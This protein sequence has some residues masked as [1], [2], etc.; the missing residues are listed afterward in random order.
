MGTVA[1]ITAEKYQPEELRDLFPFLSS[2]DM[3]ELYVYLEV[4]EWQAGEV[5]LRSG[6]PG[7][8]LGFLTAGRL[9][10]KKEG[11]FPGRFVLV[12]VLERGS[13]V[14]E[15][16]ATGGQCQAT[17]IVMEDCQFLALS[18]E[19]LALLLE[20]SPALGRK[21]LLRIIHILGQRLGKANER[22]ARLL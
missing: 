20:R 13:L 11:I 16:A 19:N 21:L 9:A 7:D 12:A 3:E 17:V 8:F 4:R 18:R 5:V 1:G 22:L 2:E 6:E 10:V 14:G 15:V